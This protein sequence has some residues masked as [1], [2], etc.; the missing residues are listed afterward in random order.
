MIDVGFFE[1]FFEDMNINSWFNL[2]NIVIK[3]VICFLKYEGNVF[4][5]IILLWV[6]LYGN[7]FKG[8]V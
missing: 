8:V 3:I 7:V 2:I 1:S 4:G 5:G 6:C